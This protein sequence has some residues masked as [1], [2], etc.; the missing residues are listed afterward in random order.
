MVPPPP[1]MPVELLPEAHPFTETAQKM[2]QEN[3]KVF[4]KPHH[5]IIQFS[6]SSILWACLALILGYLYIVA[7]RLYGVQPYSSRIKIMSDNRYTDFTLTGEEKTSKEVPW[8]WQSFLS[9]C[10]YFR[11]PRRIIGSPPQWAAR[12]GIRELGSSGSNR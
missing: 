1:V 12:C 2:R 7:C 6:C 3:A 11:V 10:C 8:P 4:I 9:S 5:L